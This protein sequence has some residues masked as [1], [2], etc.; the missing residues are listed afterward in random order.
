MPTPPERDG[1]RSICTKP[2]FGPI[3]YHWYRR[4]ANRS[5]IATVRQ[6]TVD[7]GL[8]T[9]DAARVVGEFRALLKSLQAGLLLPIEHIKGPMETVTD[10]I[11]FEIFTNTE[12]HGGATFAVRAYHH[13]PKH[14]KRKPA[15]T[16]VGLH[17]HAK[18][19]SDPATIYALQDAEL[20]V[21]RDR[22]WD[23][24]SSSWGGA[25]LLPL[26]DKQS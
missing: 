26:A 13:E 14:L 4:D 8:S 1:S 11:I 9:E 23:G 18:D 17:V 21:A 22:Y 16:V 10:L 5:L 3:Y 20:Q 6:I 19:L 7:E 24:I 25:A 15:S 12:V 2:E